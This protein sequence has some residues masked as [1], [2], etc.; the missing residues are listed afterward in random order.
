MQNAE[1]NANSN[2]TQRR[3]Q[4]TDANISMSQGYIQILSRRKPFPKAPIVGNAIQKK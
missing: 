2:N 4:P 1:P 3:E